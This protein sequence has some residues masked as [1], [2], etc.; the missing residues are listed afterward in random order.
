MGCCLLLNISKHLSGKYSQK[1]LYHA[2]QS[3][4]DA[5]KTASKR[6]I[7]KIAKGTLNLMGKKV[8]DKITKAFRSSLQNSSEQLKVKQK[9]L[10]QN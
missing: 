3:A 4:T 10:I 6:S 5:L 2:K 1:L 8:A 9:N 7:Q